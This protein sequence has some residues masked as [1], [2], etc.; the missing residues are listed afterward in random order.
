MK[1]P[2]HFGNYQIKDAL[3]YIK[4]TLIKRNACFYTTSRILDALFV[5]NNIIHI[6]NILNR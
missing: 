3:K 5:L 6:L 2:Y 1:V 4:G